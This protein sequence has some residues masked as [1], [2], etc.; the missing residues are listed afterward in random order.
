MARLSDADQSRLPLPRLHPSRTHRARPGA[1]PRPGTAH[2]GTAPPRHPG[3]AQ[4]LF[5]VA[6]DRAGTVSR[7][8]SVHPAHEVEEHVAPPEGRR[9]DYAFGA[10]I[11]R[12]ACV[13]RASSPASP[14][15][16]TRVKPSARAVAP[17]MRSA[18]SRG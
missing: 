5:Q 18:G 15:S 12:L 1:I 6:N 10:G 13:A 14:S 8:R 9:V 7:A 4:L 11:L 2:A 3:V 17:I 16:A